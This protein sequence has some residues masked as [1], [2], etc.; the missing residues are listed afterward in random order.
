MLNQPATTYNW[1]QGL[2]SGFSEN[3]KVYNKVGWLS[4][5]GRS[6]KYYHDTA[7]LEFTNTNRHFLVV[8]LTENVDSSK[9]VELGKTLESTLSTY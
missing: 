1:R 6:W 9:L 2:P 7:F 5:D 4:L 8:A 3:V